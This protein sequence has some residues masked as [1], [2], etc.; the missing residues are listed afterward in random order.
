MVKRRSFPRCFTKLIPAKPPPMTTTCLELSFIYP[1][2][3]LQRRSCFV[4]VWEWGSPPVS[5]KR[6]TEA[7]D[8]RIVCSRRQFQL[9]SLYGNGLAAQ[10]KQ[11]VRFC[12]HRQAL[13]IHI[14]Q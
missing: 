8:Y 5:K 4:P 2:R 12:E 3:L 7:A 13:L 6:D 14:E 1:H 10:W 9:K 11:L